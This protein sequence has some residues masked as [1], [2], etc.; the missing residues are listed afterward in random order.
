MSDAPTRKEKQK[1]AVE[2]PKL[3]NARRLRGISFIDPDDEEFKDIMKN[4]RRKLEVPM[5]AA[6]LCKIQREKYREICR[7]EKMCKTKKACIEEADESTRKRMQGSLR[8]NHEDHFSWKGMNSLT[9]AAILGTNLI[10]CL[11][12]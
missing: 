4:A 2:K 10:L 5:S 7:V 9:I 1:C 12:K 6:M 11:K 3:D 8:K